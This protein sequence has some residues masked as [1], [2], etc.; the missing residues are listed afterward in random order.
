MPAAQTDP[1]SPTTATTAT[2]LDQYGLDEQA[3]LAAEFA[4]GKVCIAADGAGR[5]G[6]PAPAR[7]K[8][9]A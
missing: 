9:R 7:T 4:H 1:G 5:H 3:A 2:V 8:E 6:A